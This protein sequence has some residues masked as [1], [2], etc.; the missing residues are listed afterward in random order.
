MSKRYDI[1]DEHDNIRS[2]IYYWLE[3]NFTT[4]RYQ[5]ENSGFLIDCYYLE[6][7]DPEA[8]TL[9]LLKFES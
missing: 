4:D 9:Y 3:Q 8:E 5:I 7:T 6:F 2:D 1:T